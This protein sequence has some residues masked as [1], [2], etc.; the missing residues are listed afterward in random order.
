MLEKYFSHSTV[1]SYLRGS[2]SGPYI[3]GFAKDLAE[4]GYSSTAAEGYLGTAAHLGYFMQGRGGTLADID[5]GALARF[6][7]HL[8]RCRCSLPP[9]RKWR[10]YLASHGVKKFYRHLLKTGVAPATQAT[11]EPRSTQSVLVDSFCDWL[12]QHRGVA[13]PTLKD[14]RRNAIELLASMGDEFCRWDAQRIRAVLRKRAGIRSPAQAQKLIITARVLLRYLSFQGRCRSDLD[15]AIP[16]TAH[17]RLASQPRYLTTPEV[18]RLIAACD[19]DSAKTIRDRA[20]ILLLLRLGLRA[21]DVANIRLND[22]DWE[23]GTVRVMGKGRYEVRLPLPQDAGD[24]LLRYLQCRPQSVDTDQIFLRN[25]APRKSPMTG[26]AVSV[27]VK[28]ILRRAGV[29]VPRGGAHVL[30]YTAASTMLR[31]GVDL[32]QIGLVLRHRSLGMTA[33]YAKVDVDLLRTI[34]QPWPEVTP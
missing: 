4:N 22:I 12:K 18:E 3:D 5:S 30:R 28:R 17:W 25:N 9:G 11:S 14:Y 6:L 27:A 2:P 23:N 15:Q 20:I 13:E 21:S 10:T 32:E 31:H 16:P 26:G 1:L 29:V 24:A 19:G 34:A 8:P 7:R 33:Q